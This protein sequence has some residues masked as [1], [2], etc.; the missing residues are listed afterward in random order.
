MV[1]DRRWQLCLMLENEGQERTSKVGLTPTQI[2]GLKPLSPLNLVCLGD[3][4]VAELSF[5]TLEGGDFMPSAVSA[6][7]RASMKYPTEMLEMASEV[8]DS[9]SAQSCKCLKVLIEHFLNT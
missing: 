2:T 9:I 4:L 5:Y 7:E 8:S 1:H 6:G 3:V